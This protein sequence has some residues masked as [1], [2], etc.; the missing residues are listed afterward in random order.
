MNTLQTTIK[1]ID[2]GI[3]PMEHKARPLYWCPE[4]ELGLYQHEA[5]HKRVVDS[6]EFWGERGTYET[7][8]VTCGACGADV[9]DYEGQDQVEE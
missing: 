3:N 1:T 7:V 6:Y 8:E 5:D 4:C 2:A 9:E